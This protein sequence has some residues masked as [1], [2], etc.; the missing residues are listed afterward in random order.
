MKGG[1]RGR[2]MGRGIRLS[3]GI[4]KMGANRLRNG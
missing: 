3:L 4:E 2:G 1:S